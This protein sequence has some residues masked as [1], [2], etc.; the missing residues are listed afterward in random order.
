M[1][2]VAYVAR[3]P[4]HHNA[5]NCL[6]A[7]RCIQRVSNLGFRAKLGANDW[8]YNYKQSFHITSKFIMS[9]LAYWLGILIHLRISLYQHVFMKIKHHL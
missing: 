8:G 9:H 4:H 7:K 3:L 2:R 5:T 1:L 6:C